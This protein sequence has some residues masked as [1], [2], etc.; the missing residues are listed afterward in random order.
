MN[1]F[2][3]T[4]RSASEFMFEHWWGEGTVFRH[5][6][7]LL[8][9]LFRDIF[10]KITLSTTTPPLQ[11]KQSLTPSY[12]SII[13]LNHESTSTRYTSLLLFILKDRARKWA[14]GSRATCTKRLTRTIISLNWDIIISQ[15]LYNYTTEYYIA[16]K[17][18]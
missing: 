8:L 9:V 13:S 7:F 4:N 6:P 17:M 5:G 14:Q 3:I 1:P 18:K 16:V 10:L 11:S 12:S 15:I 2:C